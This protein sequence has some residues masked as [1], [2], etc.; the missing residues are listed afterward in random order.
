MLGDIFDKETRNTVELAAKLLDDNAHGKF[1]LVIP[2]YTADS[3]ERPWAELD[4]SIRV[5]VPD[6]AVRR[7]RPQFGTV[8]QWMEFGYLF[9]MKPIGAN[10]FGQGVVIPLKTIEQVNPAFDIRKKVCDTQRQQ[11]YEPDVI[12]YLRT[13]QYR[14]EEKA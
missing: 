12:Q 10:N 5:Y 4:E 8:E 1:C 14:L 7:A 13:L 3:V 6:S 2:T 9:V 11:W